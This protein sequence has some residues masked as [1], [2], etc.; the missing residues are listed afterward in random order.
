MKALFLI[1]YLLFVTV[2]CI[3]QENLHSSVKDTLHE[4]KSGLYLS[5]S[6]YMNDKLSY[7]TVCKREK[8]TIRF[9]EFLNKP[10]ITVKY[11][12]KKM[13]ISKDSI[14]GVLNCENILVRFQDSEPFYLAEKGP[15]WI[16]YKEVSVQEYKSFR[17]EK[18]YFFSTKGN[19]QMEALNIANI[20]NAFPNDVIL[21]DMIDLHFQNADISGY[22][23]YHKMFKINHVLSENDQYCLCPDSK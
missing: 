11:Q 13:R 17:I 22:D 10:F 2:P 1:S 7:E 3:A 23:T 20:K 5:F 15:V 21:H 19:G 6:D 9:N 14:Y 12:D 18:R 16:F 8:Q 4:N